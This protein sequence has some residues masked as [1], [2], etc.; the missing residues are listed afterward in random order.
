MNASDVVLVTSSRESGPMVVKEAAACGVP[1]V[2]TDVGF[3]ADVL[4]DRP[5]ARVCDSA[6]TLVAGVESVLAAESTAA[7]PF[8]APTLRT[9]GDRLIEVYEAARHTAD[10]SS[11]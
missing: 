3:V 10:R 9:M 1:V 5:D 2:A 11:K 8:D 6:A 7:P 4:A